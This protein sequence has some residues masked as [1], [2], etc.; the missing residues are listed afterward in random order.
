MTTFSRRDA[1]KLLAAGVSAHSLS[2]WFPRLAASAAGQ[3]EHPRACIL[4]WMPGGPSQLDTFDPKPDHENGGEF[5]PISTTVPG[6][7]VGEHLPQMA[8]EMEH[9]AIIRS[10]KT[11]EGDHGRASYNLRTGYLPAG[12]IQYPTLGS[13]VGNEQ[14]ERDS[15]LPNYISILPNPFVNPAAFGPGFLGPRHAPLVVGSNAPGG[16]QMADS[17]YGAPLD[18]RNIRLPGGIQTAQADSRMELL[19]FIE[20]GF[21]ADR[22]GLPTESHRSAYEQAV[23]MMR[24]PAMRAF[25][26]DEEPSSVRDAY[27]KNRFGQACL[28]ARRLVEQG[29]S[30]VEVA[31]GGP[32]GNNGLGWDTHQDNFESVKALCET[33][34][35]A[36]SMLIRDL[37]D[38]GL[39]ETTTIL[40]MGEFGRTPTINGNTGRDHFP[41]A[42]ST[43]LA[44][45]G[46]QG[47]QVYGATTESGQDVQDNPVDVSGLLATL[48]TAL[49]IDSTNQ[50]MSRIG[51]PIP[52]VDES[53]GPIEELL[54]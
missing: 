17:D 4:L 13:I 7:Q 8:Q 46:I 14:R 25:Q 31:L 20:T 49:Q 5:S 24:S 34:D 45:G 52:L 40:W 53:A 36:W 3:V 22:P 35:P 21:A 48:L 12:P 26:L 23:R 30:F 29:V 6:V 2:G 41:N 27:G 19:K 11:K 54:A 18:V 37:R 42:W 47:G 43:V 39:L 1:L 44:G 10:M 50:N 16:A 15:D 33:L 51:R 9:L 28:L 38:R 32:D